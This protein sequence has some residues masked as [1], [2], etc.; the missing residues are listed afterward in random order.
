MFTLDQN[1]C[2]R[3]SRIGVHVGP[4]Y[5]IQSFVHDVLIQGHFEKMND[6]INQ[7]LYTEHNPHIGDDLLELSNTLSKSFK[8]DLFLENM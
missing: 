3:S 7:E 8:D 1:E 6:Y 2:S 4:E 5:A